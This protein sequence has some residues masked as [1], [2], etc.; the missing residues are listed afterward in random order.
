MGCLEWEFALVEP[1]AEL[2][3]WFIVMGCPWWEEWKDLGVLVLR[4]LFGLCG[5]GGGVWKS[6]LPGEG[7]G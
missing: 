6:G 5:E 7:G 4:C 3:E 1:E 2:W